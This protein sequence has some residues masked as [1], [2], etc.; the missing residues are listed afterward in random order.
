MNKRK[1]KEKFATRTG[2]VLSFFRSATEGVAPRPRGIKDSR[3]KIF[4]THWA[5]ILKLF[6]KSPFGTAI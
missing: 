5:M 3:Q 2:F 4:A 1:K 6:H